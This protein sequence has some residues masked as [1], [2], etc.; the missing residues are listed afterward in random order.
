M[1]DVHTDTKFYRVL[2]LDELP[3][4]GETVS[5]TANDETRQ[6]IAERLNL[7]GLNSFAGQ[8]SVAPAPGREIHVSGRMAAKVV[9]TCVVTGDML[10][11]DL[12]VD[13]ELT[14]TTD[15]ERAHV[16]V[17]ELDDENT[18]ETPELVENGQLDLGEI[19]IE[20]LSLN[21]DPYPRKPGTPFVDIST[22]KTGEVDDE[23]EKANPF[24]K[25]AALKDQLKDKS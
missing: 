15:P 2:V 1:T 17:D 4:T 25:L 6:N 22:D 10:E 16:D 14:F 19:A 11:N 5:L 23:I 9:Q 24:A 13:I 3:T 8:L 12:D 7:D 20:E 21:I 18:V